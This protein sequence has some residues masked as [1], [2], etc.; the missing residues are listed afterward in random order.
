M[1]TGAALGGFQ[2]GA[3]RE[4][5][6]EAVA[7]LGEGFDLL[8]EILD[9]HQGR[10]VMQRSGQTVILGAREHVLHRLGL[11]I[12][13]V[14]VIHK[15][16]MRGNRGFQR[17]TAQQGLAEG[18]DGADPHPAR[19]V[20][21]LGEQRARAFDDGGG[22]GGGGG[23]DLQPCEFGDQVWGGDGDPAAEGPLQPQRHFRRGRLGEG[24][25]LDAVGAHPGEHQPQQPV[26]QQLGLA[27]PG[28]GPDERGGDRVRGSQLRPVGAVARGEG[29]GVGH[30][31]PPPLEGGRWG[32]G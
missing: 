4:G 21:H 20:E 17:E 25:A 32:E 8:A 23:I 31:S 3:E 27:R 11:R 24:Q 22:N 29:H 28:R 26:G 1:L 15:L 6:V 13:G 5:F 30:S 2:V 18:V 16:E 19:Q 7:F 12:L 10:E 9:P 14:A